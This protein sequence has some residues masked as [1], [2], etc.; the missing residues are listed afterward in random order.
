MTPN[1]IAQRTPKAIR[2]SELLGVRVGSLQNLNGPAKVA[3]Q[4]LPATL[5]IGQFCLNS[6]PC[7]DRVVLRQLLGAFD[8][9]RRG[10]SLSS[11]WTNMDAPM[12]S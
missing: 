11:D 7:S 5:S 4:I 10:N 8:M 12:E 2:W 9:Q 1:D 3:V 6:E